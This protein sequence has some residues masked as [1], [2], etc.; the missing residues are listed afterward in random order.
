MEEDTKERYVGLWRKEDISNED[1]FG[2][3]YLF[4]KEKVTP[5]DGEGVGII[6]KGVEKLGVF[7]FSGTIREE[8]KRILFQKT[9][10][11]PLSESSVYQSIGYTGEGEK[12]KY[13]GRWRAV[14]QNGENV[15]GSFVL[16]PSGVVGGLIQL[17]P[18]SLERELLKCEILLLNKKLKELREEFPYAPPL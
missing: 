9:Y 5:A 2:L 14:N 12:G 18:F 6:G 13:E 3:F 4:V 1:S 17:S 10:T 8:G 11:M 7:D 16:V 15:E